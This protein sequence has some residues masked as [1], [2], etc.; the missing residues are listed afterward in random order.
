[1]TTSRRKFLQGLIAAPFAAAAARDLANVVR[2]G[3]SIAQLRRAGLSPV[4]TNYN[5]DGAP[6]LTEGKTLLI[7][8]TFATAIRD[9][10]GSFPVSIQ[11]NTDEEPLEE[12]QPLWFYLSADRKTART[13]LTAPLDPVAG[14]TYQLKFESHGGADAKGSWNYSI[15]EGVYRNTVLTLAREFTDRTPDIDAQIARDFQ[16][17][18]EVL[19]IRTP[20]QWSKPFIMP[21]ARGDNDNFGTKRTVN[22]TKKYRH[23]GL[24]LHAAMRTPVKAINDGTVVLETEQWVAGQTICIDH[25]G[26]VFSKYAHL[27][28][29]RV[30]VGDQIVQG[31]IIALSGNSG[32][33]KAPPHLHLDTIVNGTHVDP[34]DFMRTAARLVQ[35]ESGAQPVRVRA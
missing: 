6:V 23:R 35:L 19:K 31:Q 27:S 18:V 5:N 2:G 12:K 28:E 34:R 17:M 25:G 20:R 30:R 32:G 9:P 29:R 14:K 33:Q 1:M 26:G 24:D 15:R 21:T 13:I 4:L 10:Q 22:R 16:Q 3:V 11:P 8:L 7:A